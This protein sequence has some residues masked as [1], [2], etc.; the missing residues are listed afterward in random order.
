MTF[1]ATKTALG[2][3]AIAARKTREP[4][5]LRGS[6]DVGAPVRLPLLVENSTVDAVV[7]KA[8]SPGLREQGQ[9]VWAAPDRDRVDDAA[10]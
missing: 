10:G 2:G 6:S 7:P 3:T 9:A 1:A 4:R 8:E 5:T